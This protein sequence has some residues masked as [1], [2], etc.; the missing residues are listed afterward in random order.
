MQEIFNALI[1]SRVY[2]CDLALKW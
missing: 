2:L 1:G